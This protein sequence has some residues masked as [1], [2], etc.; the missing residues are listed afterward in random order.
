[1]IAGQEHP[2]FCWVEICWSGC[3]E[4]GVSDEVFA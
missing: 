2:G 4:W 1:M 3:Q